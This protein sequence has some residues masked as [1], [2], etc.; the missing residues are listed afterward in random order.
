MLDR[1]LLPP[2][3]RD[4]RLQRVFGYAPR[5]VDEVNRAVQGRRSRRRE[6][7]AEQ[8]RLMRMMG[9]Y[10]DRGS[11]FWSSIENRPGSAVGGLVQQ[12]KGGRPG[13][14]DVVVI[15][16]RRGHTRPIFIELKSCVGALTKVQRDV[17][18]E[19]IRAGASWWM[20]RSARA[21]MMALRA[22][23]VRFNRPWT[24]RRLERWEGPFR[25]PHQRL[26]G[27]PEI[28]AKRRDEGR[29]WRE[30]KRAERL[31]ART[32]EAAEFTEGPTP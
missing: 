15:S 7:Q 10:L 4:D 19:L 8:V 17:A 2:R 30:R 12:K 9:A 26:P 11:T 29:R 24:L 3:H 5:S 23:G 28:T 20:A 18:D 14:P 21:A 16:A 27:H 6:E 13:L 1:L 31:A 32:A 25:D 22:E